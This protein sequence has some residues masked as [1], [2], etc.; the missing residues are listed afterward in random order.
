M[1]HSQFRSHLIPLFVVSPLTHPALCGGG[2]GVPASGHSITLAS[3]LSGTAGSYTADFSVCVLMW[4]VPCMS[5]VVFVFMQL[6]AGVVDIQ[7]F[8]RFQNHLY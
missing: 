4:P 2:S 7:P 3:C 6:L 5:A 1:Q 8:N